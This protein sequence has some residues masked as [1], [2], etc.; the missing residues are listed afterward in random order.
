VETN[1]IALVS[2]AGAVEMPLLSKREAAYRILD[3]AIRIK[4]AQAPNNSASE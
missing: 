2:S 1:R 3:A 4:Q